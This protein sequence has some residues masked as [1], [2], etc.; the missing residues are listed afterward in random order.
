MTIRERA[1]FTH[2]S[3]LFEFA[4]ERTG[5]K[6]HF[7]LRFASKRIFSFRYGGGYRTATSMLIGLIQAT[8][9]IPSTLLHLIELIQATELIQSDDYGSSLV[10]PKRIGTV[11]IQAFG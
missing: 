10:V 2:F 3:I 7:A 4:L 11:Q 9:L 5:H 8:E 1:A 6:A